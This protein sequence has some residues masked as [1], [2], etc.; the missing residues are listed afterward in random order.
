MCA[1]VNMVIEKNWHVPY[2]RVMDKYL[3]LQMR[4]H[5]VPLVYIMEHA[6]DVV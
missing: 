5:T 3:C 1:E 4:A 2:M 6:V